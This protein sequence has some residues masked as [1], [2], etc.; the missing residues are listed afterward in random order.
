MRSTY[1]P[2]VA[3]AKMTD[4]ILF[5]VVDTETTPAAD[6]THIIEIAAVPATGRAV[7][8]CTLQTL[9]NPGV[10]IENAWIH[11]ITDS[12][13][14]SS[15]PFPKHIPKINAA[16]TSLL[17]KRVIF[18]AH[19]ASFDVGVLLREY[20]R[21]TKSLPTLDVLDT[22]SIASLLNVPASSHKLTDLA[23]YFNIVNTNPHRAFGDADTTAKV[24]LELLKAAAGKGY[25]DIDRLRREAQGDWLTTGDFNLASDTRAEGRGG[26]F[27]RRDPDDDEHNKLHVPM[28]SQSTEAE[29]DAW[30]EHVQECVRIR[31][32]LLP[33][34]AASIKSGHKYLPA[35]LLTIL[36][37][38]ITAEEW[39]EAGSVLG[40][41]NHVLPITVTTSDALAFHD[42]WV[43]RLRSVTR[44][45]KPSPT[46]I[47]ACPYCR[48]YR[49]CPVDQWGQTLAACLLGTAD[50]W[51]IDEVTRDTWVDAGGD[52]LLADQVQH[53]RTELATAVAWLVADGWI[54]DKSH[55]RTG[56]V[57][58]AACEL[59]LTHPR[60]VQISITNVPDTGLDL[61]IAVIDS[62]LKHRSTSPGWTE[63][64]D[65]R[66]TLRSRQIVLTRPTTTYLPREGTSRPV[67]RTRASRFKV[68]PPSG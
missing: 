12:A 7:L 51:L 57:A 47:D 14:L 45:V 54:Q 28:S 10:P 16:L 23:A 43:D 36:D 18:V 19:N 9:I 33:D 64:S 4:G 53:G 13:V 65:Y 22:R 42:L 52:G 32:R 68:G 8:P 60:L 30:L 37:K 1:T 27:T 17:G 2:D 63:L 20:S 34:K 46:R 41:L 5:I 21:A 29:A 55:E 59:G 56:L 58:Q 61:A 3:Y 50:G 24:L 67:G 15:D 31:C 25:E 11:N 6:G 40:I 39:V 26:T 48:A 38:H 49:P 62:A 44:C 66:S 35:R